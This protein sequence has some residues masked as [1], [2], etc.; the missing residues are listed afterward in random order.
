MSEWVVVTGAS[1]GLG[2]CL[3]QRL[4][5]DFPDMR[6]LA[7]SRTTPDSCPSNVHFLSADLTTDAGRQSVATY[8]GSQPV[9]YLI[10]NAG[11]NRP[12]DYF[13]TNLEDYR[14]IMGL[15]VEAP[16]FLTQLLAGNFTSGAR[17]ILV[18]SKAGGTYVAG[19]ATY[20]L[21]KASLAMLKQVLLED[22]KTAD[23][24]LMSPGIADTDMFRVW[25]EIVK[26]TTPLDL[27]KVL[28]PELVAYFLVFLLRD[29][30]R[31]DFRN[32]YWNIYDPSHHHLWVPEGYP[33][34]EVPVLAPPAAK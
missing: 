12:A 13:H 21:S 6:I 19:T 27:T 7:I 11:L 1:R 26:E 2:L 16:F 33:R 28:R 34:P 25:Y 9:K 30:S 10:H 29:V 18:G 24:A 14:A 23:T 4:S 32:N 5:Q 22:L 17:V 20:C 31:D 8:L 15:N 3:V